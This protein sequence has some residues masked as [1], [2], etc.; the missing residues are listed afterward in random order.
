MN[1]HTPGPWI[2]AKDRIHIYQTAHITRD[3]W[4]IPHCDEDMDLIAAAPCLLRMLKEANERLD[5]IC[6]SID[7]KNGLHDEIAEVIAKAEG[8]R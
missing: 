2:L 3:V 1:T 8:K 4:Q 5:S 6:Q 7:A